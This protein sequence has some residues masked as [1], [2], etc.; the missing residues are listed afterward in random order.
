M[1]NVKARP[2][3][4]TGGEPD[5]SRIVAGTPEYRSTLIQ[6]FNWYNN[7]K[8][9]KDARKYLTDWVK[10]NAKKYLTILESTDI[11][12]PATYGWVAR[13]ATNGGQLGDVEMSQL[14]KMLD[15][16]QPKQNPQPKA[17]VAT[18]SVQDAMK[19]KA[20]SLLGELEGAF[21][22]FKDGQDFSIKSWLNKNEIPAA[23]MPF[24]QTWLQRKMSEYVTVY[25]AATAKKADLEKD[26]LYQIKEGYSN[27]SSGD[28]KR[29]LNFFK[30]SIEEVQS[31]GAIKKA[32]RKPR[33]KKAIAPGVQVKNLKYLKKFDDLNLESVSPVDIIGAQQLWVYNTKYRKLGVYKSD[34][35][36]GLSVKGTTIQGYVP[37]ESI[38]KT[39]RKP[40]T[41]LKGVLEG[42]K[43]VL[44]RVLDNV[45]AKPATL[46][47][48]INEETIL[49]RVVK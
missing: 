1:S 31:Y 29:F 27:F 44:R 12:I 41:V 34:T 17:I 37:D 20:Q 33:A 24:I 25:R 15:S 21:D 23:Y 38:Q 26:D 9:V 6:A 18:R 10:K 42:G 35:H 36:Q 5:A 4:S 7:E 49:L 3:L 45:N 30:D 40:D 28:V 43:I 32:N 13:I 22:D 48:R 16:L 14:Y 46:N 47:G 8:D 19:E 39:L 11:Q 2:K